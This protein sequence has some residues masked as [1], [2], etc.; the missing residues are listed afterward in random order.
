MKRRIEVDGTVYEAVTGPHRG[1][2]MVESSRDWDRAVDSTGDDLFNAS[3]DIDDGDGW[4]VDYVAREY[5]DRSGALEFVLTDGDSDV[6]YRIDVD[7]DHEDV[8]DRLS[9]DADEIA[10]Q[11]ERGASWASVLRKH[12][13]KRVR[14]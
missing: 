12:G 7:P 1:R 10:Y 2:R 3:L 5:D 9:R 14:S 8:L 6:S 4:Y 11:V 13:F